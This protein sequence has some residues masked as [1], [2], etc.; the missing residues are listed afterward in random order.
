MKRAFDGARGSGLPLIPPAAFTDDMNAF[1]SLAFLN[2]LPPAFRCNNG[3][4]DDPSGRRISIGTP[5]AT[6]RIGDSINP[7]GSSIMPAKVNPVFPEAV[8]MVAAQ[9]TGNDASI[10]IAAQSGNFQL[11]VM[12][13]L[14]AHNLLQSIDLL[15]N[16]CEHLSGC[17]EGFD[18]NREILEKNLARN[19]I[20]VTAL[21]PLIGYRRAAE[22]AKRAMREN[23]PILEVALEMTDIEESRLT[24]LL[25]PARLAYPHREESE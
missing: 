10:A 24:R 22:I 14:I 4:L 12:L 7:Y 17:V 16:A 8:L 2:T 15:A 11:N 6:D 3:I 18:V 23:R 1:N 25:D 20:L 13:P 9:V 21:N 19:P 5:E